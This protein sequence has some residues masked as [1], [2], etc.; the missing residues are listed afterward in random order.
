[1]NEHDSESWR[2]CRTGEI[3][4]VANNLVLLRR[5]RLALQTVGSLCSVFLVIGIVLWLGPANPL[6]VYAG[7]TCSECRKQMPAYRSHTLSTSQIRMMDAHLKHCNG[8][9]DRY[10][11]QTREQSKCDNPADCDKG[12]CNL[13]ENCKTTEGRQASNCMS[14][15][16]QVLTCKASEADKFSPCRGRGTSNLPDRDQQP[17]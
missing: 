15:R 16:C 8:C 9:K 4:E 1:M 13:L 12:N 6:P 2:P 5:R 3:A 7:I 14:W 11:A 17:L 10:D